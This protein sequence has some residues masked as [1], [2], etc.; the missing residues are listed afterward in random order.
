MHTWRRER[1]DRGRRSPVKL[2]VPLATIDNEMKRRS[3]NPPVQGIDE[4]TMKIAANLTVL[5]EVELIE[6]AIRHLRAIGVDVISVTDLGSTD[7]TLNVLAKF[8]S[9]PD[10]RIFSI[11]AENNPDPANYG[12]Q[13]Y[14]KTV[15]VFDPDWVLLVDA[16]EFWIPRS[17]DI[18][19]TAALQWAQTLSVKR[20]NVPPVQGRPFLREN[21]SPS[22]YGDLLLVARGAA[23][24]WDKVPYRKNMP[25]IMATIMPKIMT[26]PAVA[27]DIGRGSHRVTSIS[28]QEPQTA[29]PDDLLIAHVPFST[30]ERFFR[31]VKNIERSLAGYG[32]LLVGLEAWHWKH[33]LKRLHEGRL[34]EEYERQILTSAELQKAMDFGVIRSAAA[35][36]EKPEM[37]SSRGG[38]R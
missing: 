11:T 26:K 15:E 20:F 17:G 6:D 35:Y 29:T 28:G 13:S 21:L 19:Q 38:S 37:P 9:D 30:R 25:W 16:D 5:D 32:H 34:G 1:K 7:G 2:G 10:V 22:H 33:W 23:E 14:R 31:K 18:K 8:A 4:R 36:F 27:A 24:A 3:A 12:M